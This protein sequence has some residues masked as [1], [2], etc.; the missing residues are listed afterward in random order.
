MN[1]SRPTTGLLALCLPFALLHLATNTAPRTAT[2]GPCVV[3][4][5]R[6]QNGVKGTAAG[7]A[8]LIVDSS[9]N[10]Q[11][12]IA[13]GSPCFERVDLPSSNLALLFRGGDDRIFVPDDAVFRLTGSLTLEAYVRV[14]RYP[15]CAARQ[16]QIVMRG[17]DRPG[18]DPWF[19]AIHESGQL[20]FWVANGL[21]EGTCVASPEPIPLGTLVHVAGTLHAETGEQSLWLNGERVATT[22]T[23]VRSAG[24]LGGPGAG[25][26]IGNL[27]SG[28]DQGFRG[29]IDEVRISAEALT[30]D[31]F[32]AP[33]RASR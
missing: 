32:L 15:V 10:D 12:G 11:H 17:D 2:T 14:D 20:L 16:S 27:Q 33:P 19:L 9:G 6:F 13:C 22:Q 31:R 21:N 26:G 8:Q 25:I 1:F 29:L 28:G 3:A 24:A 7:P 30:P 4:H 5:W 18:F 23:S